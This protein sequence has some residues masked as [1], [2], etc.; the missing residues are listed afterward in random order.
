MLVLLYT[1]QR[2]TIQKQLVN[3]IGFITSLY[4]IN[5]NTHACMYNFGNINWNIH[6]PSTL[7]NTTPHNQPRCLF[8]PV[9]QKDTKDTTRHAL[10]LQVVPEGGGTWS[11]KCQAPVGEGYSSVIG[12]PG[13]GGLVL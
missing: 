2:H 11:L 12:W 7:H 9:P 8:L 4:I 13:D 5:K 1:L 6:F 3:N 10:H